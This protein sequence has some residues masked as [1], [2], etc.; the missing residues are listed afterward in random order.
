[1]GLV[2]LTVKTAK[3]RVRKPHIWMSWVTIGLMVLTIA[4]GL[5]QILYKYPGYW[6]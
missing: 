1:V 6:K 2:F 4:L 5:F 3:K